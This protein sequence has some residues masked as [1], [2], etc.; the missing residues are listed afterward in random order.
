MDSKSINRLWMIK[1]LKFFRFCFHLSVFAAVVS[2]FVFSALAC[3]G[4]L[5]VSSLLSGLSDLIRI[6][7]DYPSSLL[8]S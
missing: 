3:F 8:P 2:F 6:D 1:R 7:L 5:A 4:C